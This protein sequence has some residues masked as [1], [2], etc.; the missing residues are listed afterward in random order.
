MELK[1]LPVWLRGDG[2][3]LSAGMLD[4]AHRRRVKSWLARLNCCLATPCPANTVCGGF[5]QMG[6][7]SAC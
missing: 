6:K 7:I 1:H 4:R 5:Y 3:D 2:V